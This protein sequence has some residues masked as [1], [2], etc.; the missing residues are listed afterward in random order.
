MSSPPSL[1]ESL[2]GGCACGQLRYQIRLPWLVVHC[3]HCTWCQRETGS[4]YA[5]N[6]VIETAKVEQLPPHEPTTTESGGGIHGQTDI[7]IS[8]YID[9]IDIDIG[10]SA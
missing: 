2:T 5:L 4:S 10:F 7:D 8:P 6:V 3:C 9:I 1:P